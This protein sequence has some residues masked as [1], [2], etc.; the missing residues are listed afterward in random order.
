MGRQ[1]REEEQWAKFNTERK[2]LL[3]F[4]KNSFEKSQNSCSTGDDRNECS[5]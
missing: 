1:H 3:Y 2:I 4:E 5:S